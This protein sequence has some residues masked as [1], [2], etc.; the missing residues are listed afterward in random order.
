MA[1]G[2][3]KAREGAR[4]ALAAVRLV[5]GSAALAA[6]A[7]FARRLGA[8]PPGPA[9]T[10]ALRLFGVRTVLIAWEL[11]QPGESARARAVRVAP[12]VH[13]ADT[14]AALAAGASG[15]LR[16]RAARLAVIVSATN[17]V[18]ALVARSRRD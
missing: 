4:I 11:V 10:Y 6:P 3:G 12:L 14:A 13:A 5:N 8:D 9:L 18:L 16:G 1:E 7:L 17:L 15:A 2:R